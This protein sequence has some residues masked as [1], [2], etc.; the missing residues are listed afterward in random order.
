MPVLEEYLVKLGVSTDDAGVSKFFESLRGMA[1]LA[2]VSEKSFLGVA[3]AVVDVQIKVTTAFAAMGA[4]ALK[5]VDETAMTDQ[6]YRL[7][8]L[9]MLMN[10]ETAKKYKIAIDALGN[11][12]L[13]LVRADP[14]LRGRFETLWK[15]QERMQA[16][17]NGENYEANMVKLRD[18]H[19]QLTRLEV[20]FKY[21]G[22]AVVNGL[23]KAFGTDFNGVS[24]KLHQFADWFT[25][26]L[27]EIRDKIN[28]YLVPILKEVWVVLKETGEMLG[29]LARD[30]ADLVNGMAGDDAALNSSTSTWEKVAAAVSHVVHW[31]GELIRKLIWMENH[32]GITG[33]VLGAAGG[34]AIG[35]PWGAVIGGVGLGVAGSMMDYQ[36]AHQSGGSATTS[37]ADAGY[38]ENASV[39]PQ[40]AAAL[41]QQVSVSTGIAPD[42]LWSQWAHETGGFKS[43][44][45]ANNLAGIKIP[46]T[47]T[48]MSFASLQDF[49][50]YYTRMMRAGGL[51]SGIEQSQNV[52]QF[53]ARLKQGGYYGDTQQKYTAGMNRWEAQYSRSNSNVLI[54]GTT[55]NV[56]QPNASPTEVAAAVQRGI[57]AAAARRVQGNLAELQGGY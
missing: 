11:P 8:G 55:V 12:E 49:A 42:L 5:L 31:V 41:A 3:K 51:Y 52:T 27:P 16:S 23:L 35:G 25:A 46:H 36:R 28:R 32:R 40:Q 30:F 19:F 48:Y 10:L 20:A 14:E 1:N 53:A 6:Q 39:S 56:T 24:T 34:A 13:G 9:S 54:T 2:N 44:A 57:Q 4:A 29:N 22:M 38:A 50:A 37:D 17:L 26:H 21:L 45:A 47:D 7:F 33:L 15:D 43:I 18:L